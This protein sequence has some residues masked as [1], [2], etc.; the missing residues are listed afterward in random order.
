MSALK[1]LVAVLGA[2]VTA[3]LGLG[4]SGT[5]QNV[6]TVIAAALTALGVYLVPNKPAAQARR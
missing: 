5:V 3:A 6:L 1:A 4:L 2:A